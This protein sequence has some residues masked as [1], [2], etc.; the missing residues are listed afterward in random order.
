MR[1]ALGRTLA[2]GLIGILSAVA[3][4]ACSGSVPGLPDIPGTET[5][6]TFNALEDPQQVPVL[7]RRELGEA[8]TVRRVSLLENG[9]IAE[10]R[11]PQKRQNLDR[12]TYFYDKWDVEPVMVSQSDID[13]LDE[14]TFGLG[15]VD[16]SVIPRLERKAVDSLDLED[17]EVTVVSVDKID[18]Q[19]RIYIN[20]N[21]SRGNGML[22]A[23]ARGGD[24]MVRRN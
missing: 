7:L 17:E 1:T 18:D 10:V 22:I 13:E 24:V 8:V 23:N 3:L 4:P 19:P 14:T 12:Y 15:A 6:A 20:V 16:W 11:D 5:R 2:P 21:G 9:F